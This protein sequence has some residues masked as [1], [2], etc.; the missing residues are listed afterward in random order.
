MCRV[1]E[2]PKLTLVHRETSS[3]LGS[4]LGAKE[5]ANNIHKLVG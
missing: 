3:Q 1:P 4:C 5:G 2:V